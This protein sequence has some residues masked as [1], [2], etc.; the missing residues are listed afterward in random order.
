MI[1]FI[2]DNYEDYQIVLNEKN[3]GIIISNNYFYDIYLH[4]Q[5]FSTLKAAQNAI[6]EAYTPKETV[7]TKQTITDIKNDDFVI[8]FCCYYCLM[9]NRDNNELTSIIRL[10]PIHETACSIADKEND[11]IKIAIINEI[12]FIRLKAIEQAAIDFV[13]NFQTHLQK[14]DYN[15]FCLDCK[16]VSC[17]SVQQDFYNL[18]ELLQID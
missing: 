3:I 12:E 16:C 6:I 4:H 1:S 10:Y 2:K 11:S 14:G 18:K 17:E 7:T 8:G 15:Q 5:Y 13:K 9:K